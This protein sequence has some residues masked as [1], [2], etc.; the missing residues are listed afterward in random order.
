MIGMFSFR[1]LKAVAAIVSLVVILWS[2][3]LPSMPLVGAASI[4]SVSNT[5]TDTDP[6]AASDHTIVFT[7]PTGINNGETVTIN[8]SDGPFSGTS[9]ITAAD[10]DVQNGPTDLSVA[11]NC[12]GSDEVGVS[13]AGETLTIEF[14]PGDGA[15]IAAGGTTTIEIGLS[16]GGSNQLVNPSI[17]GS[18]AILIAGT[19][20]DSGSTRVVIIDNVEVTAT[21]DTIFTFTVA[22]VGPNQ[23]VNGATT[24][25]STTATAIAFGTLQQGVA[26]T[27]AQRLSVVTNASQG[28]VVTVQQ[29]SEFISAGGATIDSFRDGSYETIPAAWQAPSAIA[30]ATS[31]YGH[32]GLTSDDATTTRSNEFTSDTWVSASTS[33]V[34]VM[35]HDGPT[36]GTLTGQGTTNVGYRVEISALQEAATNYQTRLTYIATPIF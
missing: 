30:G 8:F 14:C 11:A 9:S 27:T 19:Q 3:G 24:T 28:F 35:S 18:Y 7:T 5:L 31:T 29:D 12:G 34:I 16:A 1:L 32:W 4:S 33:P 20:A 2:L 13:F 15:S 21:V 22:G 26:S 25:G 23:S 17:P 6:G 10:I 36:D